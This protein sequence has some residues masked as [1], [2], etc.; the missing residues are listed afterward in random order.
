MFS[1]LK[2]FR[3]ILDIVCAGVDHFLV[4]QCYAIFVDLV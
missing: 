3:L 1:H 4:F 2:F